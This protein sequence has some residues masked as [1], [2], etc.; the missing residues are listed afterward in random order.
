[1]GVNTQLNNKTQFLQR[2][3]HRCQTAFISWACRS[4]IWHKSGIKGW[5]FFWD[6]SVMP[7]R[8]GSDEFYY[9]CLPPVEWLNILLSFSVIFCQY[10]SFSARIYHNMTYSRRSDRSAEFEL[11]SATLSNRGLRWLKTFLSLFIVFPF[12]V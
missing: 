2:C 9:E 5:H 7:Y 11:L 12:L 1:L 4:W 8:E 3:F 10:F 6:V